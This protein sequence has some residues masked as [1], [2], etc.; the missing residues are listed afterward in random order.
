MA[1]VAKKIK[2][3]F[4]ILLLVLGLVTKPREAKAEAFAFGGGMTLISLNPA[5]LPF[6][7]LGIA[8]FLLLGWTITNWDDIVAFGNQVAIELKALG[9]NIA[10]Y[11]T[12]SSVKVNSTFKQAVQNASKKDTVPPSVNGEVY[13]GT[14]QTDIG[15]QTKR[16]SVNLVNVPYGTRPLLIGNT[17]LGYHDSSYTLAQRESAIVI[18][19]IT[20]DVTFE[21]ISETNL[22]GVYLIARDGT[23]VKAESQTAIKNQDGMIIGYQG[24]HDRSDLKARKFDVILDAKRTIDFFITSVK[25]P[26]L[27]INKT[28]E[29]V[30]LDKLKTSGIDSATVNEYIDTAFPSEETVTFNM[31]ANVADTTLLNLPNIS[32]KVYTDA[33]I[34]TLSDIQ[35][36]VDSTTTDGTIDST[37]GT[38][39]TPNTG[40]WDSLWGWLKKLLDAILSIPGALL[41][42]LQALWDSLIKWLTDIW[43]AITAIPGAISKAWTDALTWAFGVDQVWLD[44]RL[45]NLRLAFN[46]KFPSI[47]AFNYNF[48]DKPAFD[49]IKITLPGF[50]THTVVSGSAMTAFA[51]KAKPFIS[52]IFYLLTALF[53]MRKFYKVSED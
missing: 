33:Q 9:G 23:R 53:Y 4:C 42:G 17:I 31:D 18:P 45:K 16:W 40:F 43:A 25:I 35:T 34:K 6:A 38:V 44:A 21:P 39:A 19:R 8:A 24:Y 2:I 28:A 30:H 48:G 52:G 3:W 27:N 36:G 50:G 7:L 5:I 13:T 49:D 29:P 20:F 11:V 41:A 10:D 12:G 46:R 1:S 32:D 22:N 14:L 15:L 37:T 26:E 51:V 47:Q